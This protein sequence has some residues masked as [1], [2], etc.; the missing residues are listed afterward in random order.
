MFQTVKSFNENKKIIFK[1]LI[2]TFVWGLVA[3]AYMFFNNNLSHDSLSEINAELYSNIWKIQAGRVFVPIYRL[4]THTSIALPWLIGFFSLLWIGMGVFF[5]V[6]LFDIKS[7]ALIFLVSAIFSANITVTATAASYIHDLD[8]NMFAM[9]LAVTAVYLWKKYEN[10][11]L[12]GALCLALSMGLYQSYISV[13]LTLTLFVLI[14]NI[15]NYSTTR[16]VVKKGLKSIAMFLLSGAVYFIAIKTIPNL[17]GTVLSSGHNNSIDILTNI[18]LTSLIPGIIKACYNCI[19]QFLTPVYSFPET[20]VRII[21]IA[22]FALIV[23]LVIVNLFDKKTTISNKLLLILLVGLTPL[24]MNITSVLA[25]GMI[26]TLMTYSFW[27]FYLLAIILSV[28]FAKKRNNHTNIKISLTMLPSIISAVCIMLIFINNI[29]VANSV[30]F[31]KDLEH[32]AT[33]NLF[34]KISYDL[35]NF[36]SYVAGETPVVFVNE[37]SC[38]N[39]SIP[40][41]EKF[42]RIIGAD[43]TY[44][45]SFTQKNRIQMYFDYYLVTPILLAEDEYWYEMRES[46]HVKEMPDYPAKGSIATIDGI[47][48]VKLSSTESE[49][50]P[51]YEY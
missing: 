4:L 40:G 31:K 7:D 20:A 13:A 32:E 21:S 12:F 23:I 22:I 27:L 37:P 43:K 33:Q 11:F 19:Y 16:E 49:V 39:S 35:Q 17:I 44:G 5:V 36:D 25:S 29:Q 34:V 30:Y 2:Y 26:H 51:T 1:S 50:A 28:D 24:A 14:S 48:V 41:F 42:E 6:K 9:L 3:H 47:V 10:G 45:L 8:C 38:L 46:E 15:L 18:S